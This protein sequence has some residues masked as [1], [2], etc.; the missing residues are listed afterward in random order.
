MFIVI[1]GVTIPLAARWLAIE[2][3]VKTK[4]GFIH[5]VTLTS[6]SSHRMRLLHWTTLEPQGPSTLAAIRFSAPVIV[7]R[8]RILGPGER[9]FQNEPSIIRQVCRFNC[10]VLTHRLQ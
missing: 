5:S 6:Y 9:V 10:K 8:L 4:E 1:D 3:E 2:D 7:N